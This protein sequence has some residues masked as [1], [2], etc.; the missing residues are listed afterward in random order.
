MFFACAA[1]IVARPLE[2]AGH[3]GCGMS[4]MTHAEVF[5]EGSIVV[6]GSGEEFLDCGGHAVSLLGHMHPAVVDAVKA[7]LDRPPLED[8]FLL[9]PPMAA[10]AEALGWVTP[11]GLDHALLTSSSTDAM[12][13]ALELAR[14]AGRGRLVAAG[15]T[16]PF[17]D[18]GAL[19][20]ELAEYPEQCVVLVEPVHGEGG[21]QVAP[22]AYLTEVELLC[23]EHGAL[24][25][26]DERET[27]LGRLGRW[28]GADFEDV[29]P[30]VLLCGEGLG[31]GVVPVSAVIATEAVWAPLDRD[32]YFQWSKLA[33]APVLAV[34]A[35]ATIDV[36][37]T[38]DAIE[39]A[40]ALGLTLL[41]ELGEA[42]ATEAPGLVTE[43]RGRGLLIGVELAAPGFAGELL[44]ELLAQHILPVYSMSDSSALRLAPSTLMGER[45]REWLVNGFAAA[46]QTIAAGLA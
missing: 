35:Q 7:Q 16:V 40:G 41:G 23:R 34:A 44:S 17:G 24:F 12:E 42:A 11:E 22:P 30:D 45:E 43:V 39:R 19:G 31:G 2:V 14:L 15:T 18:A 36:L 27:G 37:E 6:D 46:L 33:N 26:L 9:D 8:R 3:R 38:T 10:A 4:A 28:W 21:A 29:R 32:P 13:M 5:T 25:V 1:R 20:A